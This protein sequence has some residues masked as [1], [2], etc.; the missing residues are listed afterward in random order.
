MSWADGKPDLAV[1]D[2]CLVAARLLPQEIYLTVVRCTLHSFY[3]GV[4]VELGKDPV[5]GVD[6]H[7]GMQCL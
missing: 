4:L 5:H 7:E 1:H 2:F 6:K 3:T